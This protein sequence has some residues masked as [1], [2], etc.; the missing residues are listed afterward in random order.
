MVVENQKRSLK[1]PPKHNPQP[2]SN[3]LF[4]FETFPSPPHKKDLGNGD[5]HNLLTFIRNKDNKNTPEELY[6]TPQKWWYPVSLGVKKVMATSVRRHEWRCLISLGGLGKQCL[7]M[8]DRENFGRRSP[9]HHRC[10]WASINK[11]WKNYHYALLT[12]LRF[13]SSVHLLYG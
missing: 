5:F 10:R 6:H 11:C 13:P 7:G 3:W 8:K 1:N 4:L 12:M 2:K 9:L